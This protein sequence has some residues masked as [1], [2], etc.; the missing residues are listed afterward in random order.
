[1]CEDL[2]PMLHFKLKT[3]QFILLGFPSAVIIRATAHT[4]GNF[5]SVQA[6]MGNKLV[7]CQI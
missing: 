2:L 3:K 6:A 4:L 5:L 1:M 7:A